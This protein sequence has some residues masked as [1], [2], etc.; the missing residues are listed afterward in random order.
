VDDTEILDRRQGSQ[1]SALPFAPS[2]D[3]GTPLATISQMEDGVPM[4]TIAS[5][6]SASGA[7]EVDR[8]RKL[9][10]GDRV[11]EVVL[12]AGRH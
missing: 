5:F 12:A 4:R 2:A 9:R 3:T 1:R 8:R 6:T 10:P 11:E 7:A